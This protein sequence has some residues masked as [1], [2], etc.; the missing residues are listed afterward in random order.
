MNREEVIQRFIKNPVY[1]TNG[2]GRLSKIWGVSKEIIKSARNEARIRLYNQNEVG[3]KRL[4]FDIETSYNI[5]KAWRAGYNLNINTGD[6]IK[7]RAII[8]VSYK[9][10]HEDK[11]YNITWDENQDDK[12][13]LIKV[14][15]LILRADEVVAHNGDRFDIKWLRTRCFMQGIPFPAYVKS[16]DTLRKSRSM[17]N[18]QSNKLEYITKA[19]NVSNKMESGGLKLWDDIILRNDPI[20][21]K[22]MVAYCNQDV[23]ALEEFYL[24][25]FPYTKPETHVGIHNDKEKYSCPQCGEEHKIEKIK[26]I[27]SSSGNKQHLFGCKKCTSTYK[28]SN[29]IFKK[30][31]DDL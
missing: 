20:A 17:F 12:L 8:C 26:S 24:K 31:L 27:V 10:Q 9:W 19:V 11:V 1:M 3:F 25:M 6:I 28:I 21:M 16:L 15:D 7:E 5:V 2:A 4:F 23:V 14:A 18:F 22:Q 30:Y 13:L 29:S